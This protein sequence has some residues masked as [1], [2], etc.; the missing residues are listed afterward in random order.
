MRL[1]VSSEVDVEAQF[2]GRLTPSHN[3]GALGLV[4]NP[5]LGS[6]Q[7]QAQVANRTVPTP[8]DRAE[9]LVPRVPP[10][11]P[12]LLLLLLQLPADSPNLSSSGAMSEFAF[13]V[14][15][16]GALT[17]EQSAARRGPD[18]LVRVP[19][20]HPLFEIGSAYLRQPG[21]AAPPA[22]AAAAVAV[23]QVCMALGVLD[24]LVGDA[25]IGPPYNTA[26]YES[27]WFQPEFLGRAVDVA[28]SRLG[29]EVSD[30]GGLIGSVPSLS[31]LEQLA[32]D[33]VLGP[34]RNTALYGTHCFRPKFLGRAVN[35]AVS[36]LSEKVSDVGVLISLFPSLNENEGLVAQSADHV[37]FAPHPAAAPLPAAAFAAMENPIHPASWAAPFI[38]S[39]AFEDLVDED[40]F[41]GTHTALRLVSGVTGV[42]TE[43]RG[44]PFTAAARLLEGV[45]PRVGVN[46]A[47]AWA[48][49]SIRSGVSF[50]SG[51][52]L[53]CDTVIRSPNSM[54][55]YGSHCFQPEFLGLAVDMAVSGL[56]EGISDF[57]VFTAIASSPAFSANAIARPQFNPHGKGVRLDDSD[58]PAPSASSAP[59]IYGP[60]N[61]ISGAGRRG[62]IPEILEPTFPPPAAMPPAVAV[63]TSNATAR[64]T[65][66]P[67]GNGVRIGESDVPAPSDGTG[68]ALSPTSPAAPL[69]PVLARLLSRLVSATDDVTDEERSALNTLFRGGRDEAVAAAP[70]P[71][72]PPAPA[73]TPAPAPAPSPTTP[74]PAPVPP[75]IRQIRPMYG[76][77]NAR[78]ATD[79]PRGRLA[80]DQARAVEPV[81]RT[82]NS[83]RRHDDDRRRVARASQRT[84]PAQL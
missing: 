69:D 82:G 25:V 27:H 49:D 74:T 58:V 60:G 43:R 26:L 64:P 19:S 79:V 54:A 15:Y 3:L 84:R 72:P 80:A 83:G 63:V 71:A 24:G 73:P 42:A 50:F 78:V 8:R 45:A 51:P 76:V 41:V 4:A 66:D 5:L 21:A 22:G 67:H 57:G 28:V 38:S 14:D 53:V 62:V 20:D 48:R 12:R 81:Q 30:I 1:G 39:S 2:A 47:G 7:A 46:S 17:L 55:L 65:F 52:E 77:L 36:E 44:E 56:G 37:A 18:Y 75:R 68:Y 35:V 59:R 34:P 33:T 11:F 31:F 61:A 40:G 6:S 13:V 70:T 9:P 29:E 23:I 16:G 10:A 32:G